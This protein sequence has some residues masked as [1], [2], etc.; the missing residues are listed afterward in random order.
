[1]RWLRKMGWQ[2]VGLDRSPLMLGQA[3]RSGKAALT[4]GD[5]G[6]LPFRA[7]TFDVALMITTLEFLP[8][9]A[10]A[11]RE[12]ARVARSAIVMGVLNRWHPLAWQ[13]KRLGLALWQAA[14]F[15]TP[16]ELRD[17]LRAA[18]GPQVLGVTWRTTLVPRFWP[19]R[20]S[21]LPI[22]A[23]I[24]MSVRLSGRRHSTGL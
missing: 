5:A 3:A 8:D 17:E 4:L 13:R 24:G 18:L 10:L 2:V 6:T 7:R 19:F 23:F 14:R 9:P 16:L 21:R 22:G 12:A 20:Q 1:M 11:L 15:Y